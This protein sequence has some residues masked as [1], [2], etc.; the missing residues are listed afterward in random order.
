MD[1]KVDAIIRQKYSK[2]PIAV[3]EKFIRIIDKLNLDPL[4]DEVIIGNGGDEYYV[5]ITRSGYRIV[6]QREDSYESHFVSPLYE[7][8]DFE[9]IDGVPHHKKALRGKGDLVGAYGVL[10]KKGSQ[11]AF[12]WQIEFDE[13]DLG[14]GWWSKDK[15]KPATMI[16]KVCESQMIRM[17]YQ[18]LFSGTYDKIEML[19]KEN[20]DFKRKEKALTYLR[21][22]DSFAEKYI[23]D[24]GVHLMAVEELE[25]I[26]KKI[27][28][29]IKESKK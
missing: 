15:G 29:D 11:T 8:D 17:A 19:K 12:Y 20:G 5:L 28:A 3:Y 25:E 2:V 14:E 1:K 22:N 24:K 26:G 18:H 23:V 7:G 27:E 9:V 10:R 13:Y 4:N 16:C 21:N 6:A